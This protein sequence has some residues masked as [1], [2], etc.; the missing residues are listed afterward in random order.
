MT[1]KQSQLFWGLLAVG[2]TLYLMRDARCKRGCQMIL[3]HLLAGG[4]NA[5]L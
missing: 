1:K 4:L 3:R 2:A 5:F